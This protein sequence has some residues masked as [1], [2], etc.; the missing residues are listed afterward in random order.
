MNGY[1]YLHRSDIFHEAGLP[2]G[3]LN[4]LPGTGSEVG[5]LPVDHPRTRMIAFTGSKKV[6][7]RIAKRSAKIQP[8]QIWI[9]R[10]IAEMD[11]KNSIV[12]DETA[13]L[14]L[15]ARESRRGKGKQPSLQICLFDSLDDVGRR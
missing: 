14:D 8:G 1:S 11:G 2:P 13:D 3:V 15:A 12:V 4:F 5:D 6:G 10:P 9:K 7:L